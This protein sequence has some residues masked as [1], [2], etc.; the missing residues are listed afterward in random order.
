MEEP[1]PGRCLAGDESLCVRQILLH[2]VLGAVAQPGPDSL[3]NLL[4][5]QGTL[6]VNSYLA[7]GVIVVEKSDGGPN[8]V[9]CGLWAEDRFVRIWSLDREPAQ[10]NMGHWGLC[11]WW[12]FLLGWHDAVL[13]SN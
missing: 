2:V 11:L 3:H 9:C 10:Y 12:S 1:G 13:C 4:H 6:F 7:L 5:L 8:T